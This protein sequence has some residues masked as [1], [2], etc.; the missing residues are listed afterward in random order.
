MKKLFND[1]KN[2]K[3]FTVFIMVMILLI[4]Y[5]LIDYSPGYIRYIKDLGS[6][7][8]N[9]GRP[10]IIAIV[11]S[12]ILKPLVN[13]VDRLY[14]KLFYKINKNQDPFEVISKKQFSRIRLLTVIT[15]ILTLT[16]AI[17]MLV[18]FILEPFIN[19]LNSL[20]KELPAFIEV[21][22]TFLTGLEIDQSVLLEINNK[23]TQFF[24]TNLANLLNASVSTLTVIISHTGIFI[25]NFLVALILSVYIL[26]DKEKI[27]TFFSILID[28]LSSKSFAKKTKNFF[29]ELDKI[30]GGYFTG[31]IVDAT[32]VGICSF[33]LTAII[34]NPYAV[35]I[36]VI[37]G[38]GNVIPYLGPLIGAIGAFILGLPSGL[39]VAV[40]GFVL[41]II[42]QQIE[43]N[44]IQ[45]KIL[46]DFVGLPPLVVIVSII[47][48]GG[49][50][51]MVGII[52]ASP[53]V[54]VISLYYRRYLKKIDK[55]I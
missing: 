14:L 38:V 20:I 2:H 31:L 47:I 33:V 15:V 46:G 51:G 26:R 27:G 25:F 43:G 41:L 13:I 7:L 37:A 6:K 45:P 52:V 35:I 21:A 36:G 9:I 39:S 8:L 18:V 42:F 12:Y 4:L 48:G 19:S 49:L 29:S 17:V 1:I 5:K 54:G 53:V 30:F 50:F 22:N 32:F 40:L 10:I 28:V 23:I 24:N 3:F 11:L 16:S 55:T 34:K 44:L